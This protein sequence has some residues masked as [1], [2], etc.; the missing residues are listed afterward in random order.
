[1]ISYSNKPLR[2]ALTSA[3]LTAGLLTA[4]SSVQAKNSYLKTWEDTYPG[5]ASGKADCNLC[6]GTSTTNLNDY[7]KDLCDSFGGRIPADIA[8][9]LQN[10]ETLDSDGEGNNNKAE[11]DVNAQP[12]WTMGTSNQIYNAVVSTDVNVNCAAIGD[13]ISVPSVVPL[14]YDP[15]V[16]GEPVAVPGGPY[17]GFVNVP[18][19]FDGSGSYDSDGGAITS[20]AWDF[21]DGSTGAGVTAS[22]TYAVAGTYTV[23]L[24]VID[25]EGSSN[26]HSTTA[27]V[28]AGAVLDLDIV[29]LKA[30]KSTTVGKSVSIQLSVENPGPVKGQA[31]A[32]V[33]GVQNDVEIYR[34]SLNV[35]DNNAKGA[36]SFTFETYKPA[37]KGT[38]TW[39][40]TIADADPDFD[41][42]TVVTVI[43]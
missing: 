20:Y 27:A 23:N 28:S 41:R 6:H 39:N 12:G 43:K 29:A 17:S 42:M 31:L 8:A 26:S 35:Y 34:R 14:P 32:T 15:P 36:T 22:H 11:I 21:G 3:L 13:P 4:V 38:I 10:I 33:V 40:A 1:M 24:T 18:M 30:T 9:Y 2:R 7:G 19:T 25:D 37:A 16:S 5:S